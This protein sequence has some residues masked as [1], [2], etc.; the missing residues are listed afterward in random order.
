M[1]SNYGSTLSSDELNDLISYLM[2]VANNR[3]SETSKAGTPE[4]SPEEEQ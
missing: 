2:S 4:K 3:E 1:P